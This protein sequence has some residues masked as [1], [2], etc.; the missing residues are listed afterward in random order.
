MSGGER[1]QGFSADA[2]DAQ[3]HERSDDDVGHHGPI[4]R[5]IAAAVSA[6]TGVAEDEIFGP[7][8]VWRCCRARQIVWVI[9]RFGVPAPPSWPRLG[10]FAR[11]DYRSVMSGI[12]RLVDLARRDPTLRRLLGG[13]ECRL[14]AQGFAVDGAVEAAAR[15]RDTVSQ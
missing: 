12:A 2:P 6:E 15:W 3:D 1:A 10:R 11:R 14:R 8:Q 4:L 5:A 9:A 13:L 7:S